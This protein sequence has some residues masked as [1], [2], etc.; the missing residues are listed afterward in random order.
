MI[1]FRWSFIYEFLI[2]FREIV[3][4]NLYHQKHMKEYSNRIKLRYRENG[5]EPDGE[6]AH[7][8]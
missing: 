4:L 5:A 7:K 8:I 6:N 3:Y 2:G 1:N